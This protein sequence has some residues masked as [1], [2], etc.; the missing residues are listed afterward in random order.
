MATQQAAVT[1]I[2][3]RSPLRSIISAQAPFSRELARIEEEKDLRE[4]ELELFRKRILTEEEQAASARKISTA[5]TIVS[6]GLGLAQ[7]APEGFFGGVVSGIGGSQVAVPASEAALAAI[8]PGET[9][10]AG[11]AQV[12]GI[13]GS[14]LGAA[15]GKALPGIAIAT[16][17]ELSRR[18]VEEFVEEQVGTTAATGVNIF[19]RAL[20][21]AALASIIP[22]IGTLFGG[23]VGLVAGVAEEAGSAI[24]DVIDNVSNWFSDHF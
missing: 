14:K 8:G 16:G 18:N 19:G 6:G 4:R 22:G 15:V 17:L 23:V 24:G 1:G 21:G 12:A 2:R 3:R 13:G 7:L 10:L 11:G 5:S 9:I 20:Q